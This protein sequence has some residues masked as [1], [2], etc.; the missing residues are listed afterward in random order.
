LRKLG[1]QDQLS[2]KVESFT[3]E[4]VC[5]GELHARAGHGESELFERNHTSAECKGAPQ[6]GNTTASILVAGM[7]LPATTQP[8]ELLANLR[9]RELRCA[10]AKAPIQLQAIND[11]GITGV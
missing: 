6:I 10:D 4:P 2:V 9:T 7:P 8:L 5:A 3:L 11:V 1:L